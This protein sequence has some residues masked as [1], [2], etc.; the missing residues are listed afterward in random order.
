[1]S[2]EGP[3]PG[4]GGWD[5]HRISVGALSIVAFGIGVKLVAI[6][7]EGTVEAGAAMLAV[8]SVLAGAWLALTAIRD[9]GRK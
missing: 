4:R 3:G 1:M 6:T 2:D 8:G 9:S 7:P 5:W